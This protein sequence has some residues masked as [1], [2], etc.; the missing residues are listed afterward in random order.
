MVYFGSAEV[1]TLD[2]VIIIHFYSSSNKLGKLKPFKI[3][4]YLSSCSKTTKANRK[5]KVLE[6]AD[7]FRYNGIFTVL[8]KYIPN[9]SFK[10]ERKF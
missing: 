1:K 9:L 3:E 8:V 4:I 7:S 6:R 2:K 5:L 10:A